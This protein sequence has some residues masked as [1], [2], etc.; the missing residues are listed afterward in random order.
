MAPEGVQ[1]PVVASI[2]GPGSLDG[3]RHVLLWA[4]W[5][6]H[7]LRRHSQAAGRSGRLQG[8][9]LEASLGQACL[10]LGTRSAAREIPM[11]PAPP[12]PRVLSGAAAGWL[13][14]CAG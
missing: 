7:A 8:R 3:A 12:A 4:G 2:A 10:P 9:Q 13:H 14:R 1:R 5:G 6:S 11:T